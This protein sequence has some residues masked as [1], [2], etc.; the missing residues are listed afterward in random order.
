[1]SAHEAK[2]RGKSFFALHDAFGP[3]CAASTLSHGIYLYS[4]PIKG[5][6][7]KCERHAQLQKANNVPFHGGGVVQFAN[8]RFSYLLHFLVKVTRNMA[9][10]NRPMKDS[11]PPIPRAQGLG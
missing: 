11:I 9:V 7:R 8:S 4:M 1:M 2:L 6:N 10:M 5:G 3:T